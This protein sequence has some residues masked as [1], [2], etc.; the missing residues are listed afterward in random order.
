MN[1]ASHQLVL[2]ADILQSALK[3]HTIVAY[4]NSENAVMTSIWHHFFEQIM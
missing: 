3:N 4:E 2:P 1:G